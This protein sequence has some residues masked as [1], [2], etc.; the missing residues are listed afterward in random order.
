MRQFG[1][2]VDMGINPKLLRTQREIGRIDLNHLAIDIPNSMTVNGLAALAENAQA[3][4]YLAETVPSPSA[5]ARSLRPLRGRYGA[6]ALGT[7]L[8]SSVFDEKYVADNLGW[9]LGPK[10]LTVE[11]E[12][13]EVPIFR[14]WT[15]GAPNTGSIE[16]DHYFYRERLEEEPGR[17]AAIFEFLRHRTKRLAVRSHPEDAPILGLVETIATTLFEEIMTLEESPGLRPARYR[18]LLEKPLARVGMTLVEKKIR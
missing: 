11:L 2:I 7:T 6:S 18:F 5:A 1:K 8:R 9:W 12:E 13:S 3:A 17:L 4:L 14:S 16:P 10:G 15:R